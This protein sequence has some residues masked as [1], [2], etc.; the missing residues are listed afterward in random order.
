MIVHNTRG[1][2]SGSKEVI[3]SVCIG[4][5]RQEESSHFLN[6]RQLVEG[7]SEPWISVPTLVDMGYH[8][9]QGAHPVEML[10]GRKAQCCLPRIEM[11]NFSVM[12]LGCAR[13]S[14]Y[15]N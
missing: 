6:G 14:S 7:H 8:P 4:I 12:H 3:L 1:D 11:G 13:F 9:L 5:C 2:A 15:A 10:V